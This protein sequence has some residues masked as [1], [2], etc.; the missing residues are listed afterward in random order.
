MLLQVQ[1]LQL[2]VDGRM[3][4]RG[5]LRRQLLPVIGLIVS[6]LGWIFKTTKSTLNTYRSSWRSRRQ[7]FSESR[8]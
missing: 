5:D 1:D 7:L 8:N 2:P 6:L 3:L 4:L